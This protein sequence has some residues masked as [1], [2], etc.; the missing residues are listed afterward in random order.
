L[1]LLHDEVLDASEWLSGSDVVGVNDPADTVGA[2]EAAHDDVVVDG[3]HFRW[4]LQIYIS[5]SN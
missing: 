4:T 5:D 3:L 1:N 2:L